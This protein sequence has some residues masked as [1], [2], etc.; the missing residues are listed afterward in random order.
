MNKDVSP[1]Q[2]QL[3]VNALKGTDVVNSVIDYDPRTF[4][5]AMRSKDKVG[6]STAISEEIEALEK[7]GVWNVIRAPKNVRALHSK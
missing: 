6:W 4:G 5:E 7:N 1:T 3:F 2:E